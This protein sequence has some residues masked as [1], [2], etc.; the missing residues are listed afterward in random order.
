[1]IL[2]GVKE[3]VLNKTY[4]VQNKLTFKNKISLLKMFRSL[5]LH[6]DIIESCKRLNLGFH[7]PG[8]L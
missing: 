6:H 1:M 5:T 2:Q 3:H 7:T 4:Y 8:S